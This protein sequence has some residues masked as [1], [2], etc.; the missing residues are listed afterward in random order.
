MSR[1]F[2]VEESVEF[3][4]G[5][6]IYGYNYSGREF[7]FPA[8]DILNPAYGLPMYPTDSDYPYVVPHPKYGQIIPYLI[9]ELDVITAGGEGTTRTN[10]TLGS[11]ANVVTLNYDMYG[12]PDALNVYYNDILVAST[13]GAVSGT[14]TLTFNYNPSNPAITYITVEVVGSDG[15]MWEY[16]VSVEVAIPN[17][18]YTRR[19][20]IHS[21][22]HP[23]SLPYQPYPSTFICSDIAVISLQAGAEWLLQGYDWN[24]FQNYP[25]EALYNNLVDSDDYRILYQWL[26]ATECPDITEHPVIYLTQRDTV[27]VIDFGY[28][29]YK[30]EYRDD[31]GEYRDKLQTLNIISSDRATSIEHS[32]VSLWS[33]DSAD[34]TERAFIT[35]YVYFKDIRTSLDKCTSIGIYVKDYTEPAF[36]DSSVSL[37]SLDTAYS[38]ERAFITAYIYMNDIRTSLESC[39]NIGILVREYIDSM[40]EDEE[41]SVYGVEAVD[42][43]ERFNILVYVSVNETYYISDNRALICL[44]DTD[45][46]LTEDLIRTLEVFVY[47]YDSINVSEYLYRYIEVY[48]PTTVLEGNFIFGY[49][50]DGRQFAYPNYVDMSCENVPK[51]TR[52]NPKWGQDILPTDS[53]YYVYPSDPFYPSPVRVLTGLPTSADYGYGVLLYNTALFPDTGISHTFTYFTGPSMYTVEG[54]FLKTYKVLF[55]VGYGTGTL[56]VSGSVDRG[57]ASVIQNHSQGNASVLLDV[58]VTSS[59]L[60]FNESIEFSSKGKNP[61]IWVQVYTFSGGAVTLNCSFTWDSKYEVLPTGKYYDYWYSSPTRVQYLVQPIEIQQPYPCNF[62][63]DSVSV[64]K[65]YAKAD[66]LLQ[67]YDWSIFQ[68]YPL[69]GLYGLLVD[70]DDY[71]L[72]YE[73]VFVTEC[74]DS[75]EIN[76]IGLDGIDFGLWLEEALLLYKEEF[77]YDSASFYDYSWVVEYWFSRD[78]SR[79]RS[80][81]WIEIPVVEMITYRERLRFAPYYYL[82]DFI[83][84]S[85]SIEERVQSFKTTIFDLWNIVESLEEQDKFSIDVIDLFAVTELEGYNLSF[86]DDSF[87]VSELEIMS[88]DYINIGIEINEADTE[89]SLGELKLFDII[90][91]ILE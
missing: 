86:I 53:D 36:E 60:S 91:D 82:V 3:L 31:F 76:T 58:P 2:F 33:L 40:L 23:E 26:F 5:E 30:E 63:C 43:V 78:T 1:L 83:D 71:E 37:W 42:V 80:S 77:F 90:Y 49:I 12:L 89:F 69:D 84:V 75:A 79:G 54:G 14:G 62:V 22:S 67:D 20:Y 10:H 45:Y 9:T 50:Y 4:E 27:S 65:A 72:N 44:F 39:I 48:D 47:G 13:Y 34:F 19:Q 32:S 38:I 59:S 55:Y 16:T 61:Y 21:G 52:L 8:T 18:N 6:L 11:Q 81:V 15:T 73:W 57:G 25:I 41:V 46:G 85:W 74:P 70:S 17:P 87:T 28:I 7:T 56:N 29:S 51:E 66:W 68:S 64:V 24:S 35:A 88:V